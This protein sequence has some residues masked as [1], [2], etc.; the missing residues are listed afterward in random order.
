MGAVGAVPGAW[1]HAQLLP[2]WQGPCCP[3]RLSLF[4]SPCA[5]DPQTWTS[6]QASART[7]DW[8]PTGTLSSQYP[9]MEE[10]P[11]PSRLSLLLEPR[12]LPGPLP[13]SSLCPSLPPP[14]YQVLLLS[15]VKSFLIHPVVSIPTW[16][17]RATPV[18]GLRRP[19]P[20]C[21]PRTVRA[22]PPPPSPLPLCSSR[23][24]SSGGLCPMNQ[25]ARSC[26][27]PRAELWPCYVECSL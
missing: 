27:G 10:A 17:S 22:A 15:Q 8:G 23:P 24:E 1:A 2:S 25:T 4:Q 26:P 16:T 3:S 11:T 12:P 21:L 9:Q 5:D 13:K 18:P 19:G 14:C 20:L 7:R 6:G